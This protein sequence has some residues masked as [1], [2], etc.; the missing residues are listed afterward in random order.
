MERG[1]H[2]IYA[3][4]SR[5]AS[6]KV[7]VMRQV[8]QMKG[9]HVGIASGCEFRLRCPGTLKPMSKSW[10]FATPASEVAGAARRRRG[11]GREHQHAEGML[12]CGINRTVFRHATSEPGGRELGWGDLRGSAG[13]GARGD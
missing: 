9:V 5:C 3:T 10:E 1:R 7:P 6:L 4:L 11:G 13:R 12:L 2:F 8:L